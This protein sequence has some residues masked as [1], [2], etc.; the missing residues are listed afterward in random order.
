[1]KVQKFENNK[2]LKELVIQR[3]PGK[4]GAKH[5]YE[6]SYLDFSRFDMI[7][8]E[9]SFST[10]IAASNGVGGSVDHE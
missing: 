4:S 8:Q 6:E 5:P 9:T 3:Q 2:D 7:S 10:I 1:M